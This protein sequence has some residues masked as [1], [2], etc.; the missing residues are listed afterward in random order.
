M[1]TF[2]VRCRLRWLL[3]KLVLVRNLAIVIGLPVFIFFTVALYGA[4]G[5]SVPFIGQLSYNARN[6]FMEF[7]G[8]NTGGAI[9]IMTTVMVLVQV[10][11]I[12]GIFRKSIKKVTY[13]DVKNPKLVEFL[14]ICGLFINEYGRLMPKNSP[15]RLDKSAVSRAISGNMVQNVKETIS[16]KA[17]QTDELGQIKPIDD[18]FSSDVGG[19]FN[20]I[21][22]ISQV[23]VKQIVEENPEK[24]GIT[25]KE[26]PIPVE[27][28]KAV[29]PNYARSRRRR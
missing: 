11:F 24:F 18:T 29:Q 7:F 25:P 8:L 13:Q 28:P 23:D 3:I 1:R 27:A 16:L 4:I 20:D 5:P 17:N 15:Q 21:K 9:G 26:E 14:D 19:L 6:W 12:Y 10:M 22:A 2:L